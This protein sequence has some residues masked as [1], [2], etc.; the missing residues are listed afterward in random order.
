MRGERGARGD[1]RGFSLPS[2]SAFYSCLRSPVKR[3]KINT[4][5]LQSN[6]LMDKGLPVA[7]KKTVVLRQWVV[8]TNGWFFQQLIN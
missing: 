4:P 8:E 7:S 5:F 3:V 2:R 1:A 6:I